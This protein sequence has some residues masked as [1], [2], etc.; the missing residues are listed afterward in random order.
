MPSRRRAILAA[1]LLTA[2]CACAAEPAG[3]PPFESYDFAFDD[4]AAD[5][6]PNSGGVTIPAL[7]VTGVSGTVSATEIVLTLSFTTPVSM[8]SA[9][10]PNSV[11]GFL[12]LD[13]DQDSATGIPGA[14]EEFGGSAPLGAEYYLSLREVMAGRIAL[15]NV[16][17]DTYRT[18]PAS[19]SGNTMRIVVPRSYLGDEDGQFHFSL[20]VGAPGRPATD[21]APSTGYYT[22]ARP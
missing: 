9:A 5:T 17:T 20:V 8:W 10:Q 6:L 4:P 15:V 22:A 3:P 16:A 7:D 12:D 19:V 1:A 21:F 11:D 13:L 14:A 2:L 18:V